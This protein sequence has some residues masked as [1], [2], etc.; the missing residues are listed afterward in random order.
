V[1]YAVPKGELTPEFFVSVQ[2]QLSVLVGEPKSK[3]TTV[4]IASTAE[5]QTVVTP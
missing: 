5:A 3:V 2:A 1:L 4:A